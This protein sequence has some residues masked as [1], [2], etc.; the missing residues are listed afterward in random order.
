MRRAGQHVHQVARPHEQLAIGAQHGPPAFQVHR[1]RMQNAVEVQ[2]ED[3]RSA[4]TMRA[5]IRSTS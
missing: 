5:L 3:H 4:L 2:E 1:V